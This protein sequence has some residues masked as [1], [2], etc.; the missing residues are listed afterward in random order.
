MSGTAPLLVGGKCGE[1]V[2]GGER[3]NSER[4]RAT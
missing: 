3:A 4:Y 1:F 2:P